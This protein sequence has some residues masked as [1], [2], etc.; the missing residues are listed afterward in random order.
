MKRAKMPDISERSAPSLKTKEINK[1][2]YEDIVD[3]KFPEEFEA[4]FAKHQAVQERV[5][6]EGSARQLPFLGPPGCPAEP[7]KAL[8]RQSDTVNS[9]K[10]TAGSDASGL[11]LLREKWQAEISDITGEIPL[12][13]PPFQKV[14]HTIPLVDPTKC[15]CGHKP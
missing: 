1:I 9:C 15:Y 10:A 6:K 13:L 3:I 14:N 7:M 5:V 2:H 8:D 12:E 11:Q 4:V